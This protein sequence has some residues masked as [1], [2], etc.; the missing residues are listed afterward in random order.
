M[1]QES[2]ISLSR[3]I[4]FWFN[5]VSAKIH[6]LIIVRNVS[7][8]VADMAGDLFTATVPPFPAP[9]LQ[10]DADKGHMLPGFITTV[11]SVLSAAIELLAEFDL[12]FTDIG[13]MQRATR[14]LIAGSAVMLLFPGV[15][16]FT[17]NDIDF[18]FAKITCGLKIIRFLQ[19][20]NYSIGSTHYSYH[21]QING[22]SIQR[23]H[24]PHNWFLT[25]PDLRSG[26]GFAFFDKK[27][28]LTGPRQHYCVWILSHGIT[29]SKVNVIECSS[30]YPFN[31]VV[32]F[33]STPVFVRWTDKVIWVPSDKVIWFG[34]VDL[35]HFQ[36]ICS[37][38][39]LNLPPKWMIEHR[40]SASVNDIR[41]SIYTEE[42]NQRAQQSFNQH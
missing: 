21:D 1:Y 33:H 27:P 40:N 32:K 15:A 17:L 14:T 39:L 13:L 11:S 5:I 37:T 41:V 38:Q 34:Y 26:S 36:Q 23:L 2:G 35:G 28:D 18:F 16:N 3:S 24:G 22:M 4:L 29:G 19:M 12:S 42:A 7:Q 9:D 31:T 8:Y 6:Q 10:P 30:Y 25:E 20:N